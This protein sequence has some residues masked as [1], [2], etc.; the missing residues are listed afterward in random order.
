[1]AE[2]HKLPNV[3]VHIVRMSIWLNIAP[4]LG[5][6]HQ[7]TQ[8]CGLRMIHMLGTRNSFEII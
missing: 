7:V 3:R 8:I 4:M 1:M 5:K 2:Y 6:H